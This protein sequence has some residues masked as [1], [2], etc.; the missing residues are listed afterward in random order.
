M[1]IYFVKLFKNKAINFIGSFIMVNKADTKSLK[2]LFS[3][4]VAKKFNNKTEKLKL[5]F[6]H[7]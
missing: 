1:L 2:K 4:F 7:S 6:N 3:M 5:N